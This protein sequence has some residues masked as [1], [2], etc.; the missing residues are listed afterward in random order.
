[1]KSVRWIPSA[2]GS[3]SF[4]AIGGTDGELEIIDLTGRDK[5]VGYQ[6]IAAL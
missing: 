1:M 3:N 6:K 2:V 4:L 5:C